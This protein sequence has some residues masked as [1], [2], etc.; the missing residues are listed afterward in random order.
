MKTKMKKIIVVALMFGTLIGYAN[1]HTNNNDLEAKKT[2]KVKF[3]KK[4]KGQTLSIK[5]DQGVTVYNNEIKNSGTYSKT[6]DF[7]ALEDG[8]YAAELNKDF[9]IVIKQFYVKNGLVTFLN[10][11]NEKVFKP[12]I[13]AEK[14]LLY[15][16]KIDFNNQPLKIVI[17]YK[18]EAILSE[19]IEGEKF[20]KRVYK[21]SENEAGNYKVI[22]S[23]NNRSYVKDFTI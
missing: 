16:S 3:K 20:L 23:T 13:R 12:V 15:V 5:N 17:Y 4:K 14:H 11:K 18:N 1:E 7:S 22:I 19:T 2:V 21:L 10:N 6:F 8:I 9:E